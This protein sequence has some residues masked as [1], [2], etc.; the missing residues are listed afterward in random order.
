MQRGLQDMADS[1]APAHRAKLRL[2]GDFRLLG[3]RG[4]AFAIASRRARG[5]LAYLA[6]S[7]EHTAPRERL[8]GLL[9]SDR[10]EAQ[11]RASLRQCLLELRDVMSAAGL[12]FVERRREEIGLRPE[13]FDCDVD[14]LNRA[15]ETADLGEF[16][17]VLAS[18]GSDR[19]LQDL[20]LPGLFKEWLDQARAQL[21]RALAAAVS[22][23]I[24]RLEADREWRA[25]AVLT[26][27]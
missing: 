24:E 4:E 2:V 17:E 8:S 5:L 6:L 1:S 13:E 3:R 9:W 23:R 11:A 21:D 25:V 19:L 10:G 18:V 7:P 20:E 26:E 16:A 22:R 12:D 27:A 14:D 15:I